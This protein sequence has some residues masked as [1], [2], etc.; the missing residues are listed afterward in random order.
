MT[1]A[2][3][4]SHY[5]ERNHLGVSRQSVSIS[6]DEECRDKEK[7]GDLETALINYAQ[8]ACHHRAGQFICVCQAR[9][10]KDA[11]KSWGDRRAKKSAAPSQSPSKSNLKLLMIV[12]KG[13]A[14]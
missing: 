10:A 3:H 7:Q 14:R 11:E 1:D 13:A 2:S 9:A 4:N 8:Q 6:I 12:L 5:R